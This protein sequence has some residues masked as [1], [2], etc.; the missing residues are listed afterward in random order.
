MFIS[1]GVL[2]I[3]LQIFQMYR[4]S[5]A[6]ENAGRGSA[7]RAEA[8]AAVLP[9]CVRYFSTA[10][11]ALSKEAVDASDARNDILEAKVL[12]L[13]AQLAKPV[14]SKSEVSEEEEVEPDKSA[15]K[16]C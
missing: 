13:E 12:E 2:L 4:Q 14:E 9:Y 8:E 6:T 1:V 11:N 3:V 16:S 5:T 10:A 7:L 15:P